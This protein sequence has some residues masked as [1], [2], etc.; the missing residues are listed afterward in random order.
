M[1]VDEIAHASGVVFCRSP[2]GGFDLA[3][4]TMNVE[5]NEEIDRTIATILVIVTF[6][7][8]RPGR[9]WLTDLTDELH[10]AFVEAH[11]RPLGIGRFGIELE[12]V[13]HAGDVFAIDLRNAP[14]VFTPGLEVIFGQA[15]SNRLVRQALVLGALD[16]R[17]CQQLNRPAGAALGTYLTLIC[18]RM[19]PALLS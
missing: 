8:T 2:L 6:E 19:L 10:R 11:H 1:D 13:L 15:P 3:P 18:A 14:H 4:G 9:D 7:L 16:H 12:Y 17:A 5:E